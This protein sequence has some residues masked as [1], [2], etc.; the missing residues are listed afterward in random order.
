MLSLSLSGNINILNASKPIKPSSVIHG[1]Q[2]SLVALSCT[3]DSIITGSYDGTVCA[4]KNGLASTLGGAKHSAKIAAIAATKKNVVSVGWDDTVRFASGKPLKYTSSMALNA[5]PSDVA[6]C[7]GNESLSAVS[8]AKGISLFYDGKLVFE[9]PENMFISAQWTPTCVAISNDGT[10][11]AAGS[12]EMKI[13]LFDIKSNSSLESKADMILEGHRGALTCIEFSPSG[14]QL[15]AGDANREIR[16]WDLLSKTAVVQG[17]WVF[18]TTRVTSLSWTPSGK[19]VASG[20]LDE[21]VYIWSID[22]P[23]KKS[24]IEYLHKDGVTGVQFLSESELVTV[25]NDGCVNKYQITLP[26]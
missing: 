22:K 15:A 26:A 18:H 17:M 16:I 23:M 5:Q 25:G 10:K 1:H 14:D 24:K 3:A 6:I 9:T 2:V 19:F 7:S 13:Y 12:E 11:L 20:S 21:H 4:W 8:T